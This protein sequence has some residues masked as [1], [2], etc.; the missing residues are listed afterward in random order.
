MDP[1]EHGRELV[2]MIEDERRIGINT[3]NRV[4]MRRTL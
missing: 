4:V 2:G 1:A 3:S